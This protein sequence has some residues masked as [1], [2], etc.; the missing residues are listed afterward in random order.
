MPH[1]SPASATGRL[2]SSA[3][4]SALLPSAP[5]SIFW[6]AFLLRVLYLTVAHTYRFRLYGFG[7][8]FQFGWEMGRIARALVTGHGYADPFSGHT[9]PT[10]WVTPLYPL[11]LAGV[12]KL[13]GVYS[14]ASA[15]VILTLNSLFSAL[16][17]RTVWEIAVRCFNLRVARW[18][19][20]I[21]A[22][23][24]AAMQYAVRWVWEMTL[25]TLLFTALL[26]VALRM[27]RIGEPSASPS[28]P[29]PSATMRRWAVFGALSGLIALSNPSLLPFF[30]LCGVWILLG[31]Y[32]QPRQTA[33]ILLSVL[34]CVA[35][36]AP[37]SWRNWRTF[38]ALIPLRSNFGAE[39]YMGNGPGAFGMLMEYDHPNQSFHELDRYK[40]LGELRYSQV[41]GE[42]TKALIRQQ[43]ARFL[44]LSLKRVYYFWMGV[45]R[46]FQDHGVLNEY[47]RD[48][49]FAFAS[50]A[51]LFGLALALHRRIPASPLI[52][53]AF[54]VLPAP[55]YL[56]S[57]QA[58][59]RHPLEPLIVILAVYLFQSTQP[60]RRRRGH[61]PVSAHPEGPSHLPS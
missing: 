9:G 39:L 43:P 59:F 26:V 4:P 37:W 20:W 25:T 6:I 24:P 50:L 36:V 17:T 22:L 19:A 44:S 48:L 1:P 32:R 45:P 23:Y 42:R 31:S 2:R 52:A 34:V 12:F 47:G 14:L 56:V 7:L 61:S 40:R 28:P 3:G 21:W 58:R 16:T 5:W 46:P 41:Q 33:G 10:A 18:S 54:L 8:H 15:W 27:R 49:N 53:L 55:Y 13:F 51:G 57:V 11:L 60:S 29:P 30:P 38:H 35:L